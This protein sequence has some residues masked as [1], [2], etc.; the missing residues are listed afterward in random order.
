MKD[1]QAD[2]SKAKTLIGYVP[3]VGLEDGLR[4]TIEWFRTQPG[5]RNHESES[6]VRIP[7][8]VF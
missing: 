7:S 1:S 8:P 3:A 2:I 6:P 5:E 4:H